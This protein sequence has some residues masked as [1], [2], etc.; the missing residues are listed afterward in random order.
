M[1]Y[2]LE[3]QHY[4]F[5]GLITLVS[6]L[7]LLLLRSVIRRYWKDWNDKNPNSFSPAALAITKTPSLYWCLAVALHFGIE[8]SDLLA[9]QSQQIAKLIHV[10]FILSIFNVISQIAVMATHTFLARSNGLLLGLVRATFLIV[11]ILISLS[12]LGVSVAPLLTAL[13][14][15]GVAVALALKNTLENLFA[16]LYLLSEGALKSGDLIK[17]D[18]GQEGVIQDI[19]WRAT[20]IKNAQNNAVLIPNSKLSQSIV[21][22]YNL[23]EKKLSLTLP[24]PVGIEADFTKVE[25]VLLDTLKKSTEDVVGLLNSPEGNVTFMGIQHDGN[26]LFNLNFYI[27]D[28]KQQT[29]A[30][31]ELR[32]R[33]FKRFVEQQISLPQ[34][35]KR[36]LPRT[37]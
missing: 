32:K 24:I 35:D 8:L 30:L 10:A 5:P 25:T 33:I 14:V 28:H 4:F 36:F 19:G 16:G 20:T 27:H 12:I 29:F 3:S 34:P 6:L 1:L 2:K 18:S 17:L 31:S 21:T 23:P 37:Q 11:G 26:L 15:G 13:G 22:N 9:P 7:V